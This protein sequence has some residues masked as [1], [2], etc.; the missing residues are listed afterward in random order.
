MLLVTP[1][2]APAWEY[3]GIV[4]ATYEWTNALANLGVEVDVITTSAQGAF[5]GRDCYSAELRNVKVAYYRRV[6][7]SG[8]LFLSLPLARRCYQLSPNYD[9]VHS[10]GLWSFPSDI[11]SLIAIRFGIPYIVSLHGMLMPIALARH[12]LRKGVMMRVL[13][14]WR[15]ATADAVVCA[16]QVEKAEYDKLRIDDNAR[17]V[18]NIV[19]LPD[20]APDRKRFRRENKL[21]NAFMMLFA[22]R[23]VAIKGLEYTIRAFSGVVERHPRARLVIVGPT[24]GD[25]AS[26]IKALVRSLGV[27]KVVLFKGML[28]GQEYWDTVASADLLVL[29]SHSENFGLVVAQAMGLG[30]PVLI[31]DRVGLADMVSHYQAGIVTKLEVADIRTS[32]CRALVGEVDLVAMG[33]RGKQLVAN[34]FSASSVGEKFLDLLRDV[35]AKCTVPDTARNT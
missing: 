24:E 6:K 19:E 2:Y 15:L 26:A 35:L 18:P 32:M 16:S 25:H 1:F 34:H 27:D 13:E 33:C 8:N 17:V 31:S 22:G 30:V 20:T 28:S 10:V 11:S 14:R 9:I 12:G 21:E 7:W 4:R 23:L 3:G 5:E 29:N